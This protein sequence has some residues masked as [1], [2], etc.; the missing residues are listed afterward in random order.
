MST[1]CISTHLWR[2]GVYWY[3]SALRLGMSLPNTCFVISEW[4]T[5][6]GTFYLW[7]NA[8]TQLLKYTSRLCLHNTHSVPWPTAAPKAKRAGR[9]ILKTQGWERHKPQQS[10]LM[11]AYTVSSKSI[12]SN[13]FHLIIF[14]H[15]SQSICKSHYNLFGNKSDYSTDCST[16]LH[17]EESC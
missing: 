7:Q 13:T 1:L 9:Y 3:G 17:Q 8:R 10:H 16:A 11:A 12:H 6:W 15:Y 4:T 5:P 14:S 2:A